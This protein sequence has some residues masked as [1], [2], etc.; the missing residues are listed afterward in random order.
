MIVALMLDNIWLSPWME[1]N[2][3]QPPESKVEEEELMILA[4]FSKQ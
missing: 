3:D 1:V 2:T 4:F